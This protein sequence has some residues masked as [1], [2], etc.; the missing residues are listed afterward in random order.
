MVLHNNMVF[1][2]VQPLSPGEVR[3]VTLDTSC[4]VVLPPE[5]V[6]ACATFTDSLQHKSRREQQQRVHTFRQASKLPASGA[7]GAGQ[8]L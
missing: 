7:P 8:P 2:H 3:I 5:A 4:T 1:E 6:L